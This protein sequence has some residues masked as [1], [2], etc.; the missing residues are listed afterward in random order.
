[1]L[2]SLAEGYNR[3]LE[4]V[5]LRL[6]LGVVDDQVLPPGEEEAHVAG[7]GLGLRLAVG[8][9]HELDVVRR[10]GGLGGLE[11]LGVILFNEDEDF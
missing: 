6:I 10:A 7:L 1:V 3:L 4:L 5:G 11:G 2:R 9:D 8:D